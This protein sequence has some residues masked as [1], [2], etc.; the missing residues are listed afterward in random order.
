LKYFPQIDS[1]RFFAAFCVLTA[2]WLHHI[3][4]VNHLK[5]GF[6]GVDF[7]FVISGFLISLKLYE[8]REKVEEKKLSFGTVIKQFM[9]RRA[10]RIFPIY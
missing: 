10:F 7:F 8:L 1:F 5:L 9:V 4:W 3:P 2:H 6:I